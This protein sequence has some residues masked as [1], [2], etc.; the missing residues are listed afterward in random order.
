M[1]FTE[2]ARLGLSLPLRTRNTFAC[3]YGDFRFFMTLTL[4]ILDEILILVSTRKSN[5]NQEEK[6]LLIRK[7]RMKKPQCKNI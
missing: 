2:T 4:N 5:M 1:I 3:G 7:E 6:D